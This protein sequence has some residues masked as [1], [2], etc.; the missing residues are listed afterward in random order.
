MLLRSGGRAI[1]CQVVDSI[2]ECAS[3]RNCRECICGRLNTSHRPRPAHLTRA[4]ARIIKDCKLTS[5]T[6][7]EM[8]E[9]QKLLGTLPVSE[10]RYGGQHEAMRNG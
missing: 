8:A 7:E 9:I 4:E 1:Q 10:Q 3:R 5:L 6:D 2:V